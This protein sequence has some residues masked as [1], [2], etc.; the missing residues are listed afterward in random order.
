MTNSTDPKEIHLN[1]MEQAEK[2]FG[3]ERSKEL[4]AEIQTMA[5]Q[6]AN[7]RATPVDLQDEP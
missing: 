2:L 7:L 3:A 4:Q 6:L 1:L 5:E